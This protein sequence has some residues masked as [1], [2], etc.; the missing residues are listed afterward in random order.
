[1]R[2]SRSRRIL[3]NQHIFTAI[4]NIPSVSRPLCL[5]KQVS[6]QFNTHPLAP[7]SDDPAIPP[8]DG[9]YNRLPVRE[10]FRDC[11]R[12]NYDPQFVPAD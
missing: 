11:P 6:T 8:V 10:L 9:K 7:I 5:L 12:P 3:S 2:G 4:V 1:M